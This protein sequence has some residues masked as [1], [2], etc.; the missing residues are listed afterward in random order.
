M[1]KYESVFNGKVS[2]MSGETFKIKLKDDAIP[3]ASTAPRRVA[4]P[5]Q[6]KLNKELD[7][8][9]RRIIAKET[10]PT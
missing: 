7:A 6:V 9:E 4:E 1:Q 10:E 5:L 2:M 8:L 3:Y